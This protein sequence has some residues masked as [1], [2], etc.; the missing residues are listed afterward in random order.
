MI[1]SH[2]AKNKARLFII[3]GTSLVYRAFHAI[4]DTLRTSTGLHTNAIY[5]FTQSITKILKD[6]SPEYMAL[7]FDMRGP[8]VRHLEYGE[9]K[10]NRPPMP[11]LLGA[12]LPYIKDILGALRIKVLE[13]QSFEADDLIA[14][15]AV[16]AAEDKD[17]LKS[18]IITGD[19]DLYQLVGDGAVILDYL[20]GRE[21]E[22]SDVV[23]KFGVSPERIRDMLALVG[24]S[25]DNIPGVKGI[26]IKTAIKLINE[27]GSLEDIYDNIKKISAVKL[28]QKLI[29]GRDSAFLSRSL[30]TLRHDVE[31]DLEI[32][33]LKYEGPDYEK[34]TGILKELE[35]TNM[36]KALLAE[37]KSGDDNGKDNGDFSSITEDDVCRVL[38]EIK[39]AGKISIALQRESDKS[40]F[41]LAMATGPEGAY[42]IPLKDA[43][44]G[45]VEWALKL[46]DEVLM[47]EALRKNTD[48][49]KD[50]Y[51]H[52]I[53]RRITPHSIMTDTTLASYLLNPSKTD[54]RVESLVL[55][56]FGE[57]VEGVNVKKFN[58]RDLCKKVCNI[59][60]LAEKLDKELSD[61]GLYGLYRDIEL[62]L[63]YVLAAMEHEGIEVDAELL[64]DFSA[65]LEI[66]LADIEGSIFASVGAE[67]NV[68][69]PKQLSDVLFTRLNLKPV[70]KTKTGFSTNEAV[71][72]KLSD[73]HEVP[74]L[75][76]SFRELSKLRSTYV[77]GLLELINPETGRIHTT[78]NQTITATGRLS[79]SAPNMQN[80]P[81]KGP[82]AGRIREAFKARDGFTLL[83]ADY[84]QIELRLVAHLSG[85]PA[86]I[87]AFT[88]GDDI[89][90]RTASELF[91]YDT[92]EDV[93]AEYRRRAKAINFGIIYGMG[94]YGLA[95]EL[96]I[97]MEEAGEYIESYFTHYAKVK[98]FM[99]D[100]VS[101]A[102]ERGYTLT[103]FGRRR[104]VPELRSTVEQ[105]RNAGR[106]M[107][108]NTPVQGS[109][110]DIIKAAM[111]SLQRA[112]KEGGYASRM[113]LQI[114]DEL[115]F[116]TRLD[117][118][119]ALG[120]LVKEEMEGVIKLSVPIEVN[121]KCGANWR[122][123]EPL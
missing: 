19:K 17:G 62:P 15:L 115:I 104:F 47:D 61:A 48:S 53:S 41:A 1:K 65:E 82:M 23:N 21:Y 123:A 69:S 79:S 54:H 28:R 39:E 113:I 107:A 45:G 100:T 71:L 67:F 96:G 46:L 120:S 24:D 59:S 97:S 8:T 117:E 3:D 73:S 102:E 33:D 95:T 75:V 86:L 105:V 83:S 40:L 52:A 60:R 31:L 70:K 55:E 56:F 103:L 88:R 49:S 119:E 57:M 6:Y 84:S 64:K 112:V 38:A 101:E 91:G 66:K 2:M 12:Q 99:D 51:R 37:G 74:A 16:K 122:D 25:S 85:D 7:C 118:L 26:G 110:A 81:Q 76:L 30:A 72:K 78:F 94:P 77:E 109:S 36:L 4:P 90:S 29:E 11:D 27:Y 93:P 5:G 80:I 106:R 63:A 22:E 114:H 98:K 14:A 44:N 43:L 58:H 89:H 116:E 92:V 18:C 9:Y 10:A 35:F 50:L 68:N 87:E 108:I 34:L 32:K 42:F 121:M 13:R 111:V 20:T